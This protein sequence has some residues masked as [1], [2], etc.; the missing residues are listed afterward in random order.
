MSKTIDA[1][2]VSIPAITGPVTIDMVVIGSEI[3]PPTQTLS[4]NAP[5]ASAERVLTHGPDDHRLDDDRE[6]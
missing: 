3:A 5:I 1:A 2:D 4:G 6:R